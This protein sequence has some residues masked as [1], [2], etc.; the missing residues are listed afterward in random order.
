MAGLPESKTI[1]PVVESEL[2]VGCGTCCGICPTDALRISVEKTRG[3][4]LPELDKESCNQCGI[5][6]E[7][8]PGHAVDFNELN[9]AI[10]GRQPEDKLLGNY[11]HFYT[12][13]TPDTELRRDC[14]SG[15]L[16][17]ALLI[18]ALEEG[19]IDGALVTGMSTEN[20]L[21]PEVFIA[22]TAEDVIAASKSKYCPVPAGVGLK[23]ILKEEGRFAFVGLPCHIHGV[24]K[25]ELASR[26]L[27]DRIVLH[28]GILCSLSRTFQATE[29]VLRRYK[30]KRED[31]ARLD[32][33]GK[34]WMGYMTI[35]LKNGD[36]RL[37][38]FI[39]YYKLLLRNY[40]TPMRCTLCS[41]HSAELA[42]IS[43]GDIFI[44]EFRGDK[45]GISQVIS[46][47]ELGEEFLKRAVLAGKIKLFDVGKDKVIKSQTHGLLIKKSYLGARLS[48]FKR[49]GKAIPDYNQPVLK[50]RVV[51][52]LH[53]L[54]FYLQ[55]GISSRRRLWALLPGVSFILTLAGYFHRLIRKITPDRR[56]RA[57]K[58]K[59]LPGKGQE[60]EN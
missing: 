51:A 1:E 26:Q 56:L 7:A 41:D 43:L 21:V 36:R 40:F 54:F 20:P 33:R 17:T 44:P 60:R 12:G 28:L 5:C 3:I 45:F 29:Y 52:Y 19:I 13:Y 37:F 15:G 31:I 23:E 47:N 9:S 55:I 59:I 57:T 53:A 6:F 16:V 4:Y 10:F 49:L 32:Y 58:K 46:R 34:G 50:P 25:A 48:I 39:T 30:I 35:V 14:S 18:F 24:R 2:C 42:D 22:R 8:C 38:P 27:K 11:L